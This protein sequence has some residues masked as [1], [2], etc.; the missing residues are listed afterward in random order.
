MVSIRGTIAFAAALCSG[1][2][3]VPGAWAQGLPAAGTPIE[4][5]N[6]KD[7]PRIGLPPDPPAVRNQ[8]IRRIPVDPLTTGVPSDPVNRLA[9][10]ADPVAYSPRASSSATPPTRRS[11]ENFEY[12]NRYSAWYGQDYTPYYYRRNSRYFYQDAPVSNR[13]PLPRSIGSVPQQP[14]SSASPGNR[15]RYYYYETDRRW[16]PVPLN[17]GG[18]N[19]NLVY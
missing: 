7:T 10:D 13:Y 11:I 1:L 6:I 4:L 16:N 14:V 3:G 18:Y 19:Y 5:R 12:W 2:L 17:G 8:R 15:N 9:R